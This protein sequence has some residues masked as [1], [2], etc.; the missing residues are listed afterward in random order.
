MVPP[1]SPR[2]AGNL[3]EDT[4]ITEK[5]NV[6]EKSTRIGKYASFVVI[7]VGTLLFLLSTQF[8]FSELETPLRA[9]SLLDVRVL[10]AAEWRTICA[11]TFGFVGAVNIFCGLL[12]LATE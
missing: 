9:L 11:I 3:I 12:M 2:R 1:P 10:F 5:L 4:I 8:M 6:L 7:V